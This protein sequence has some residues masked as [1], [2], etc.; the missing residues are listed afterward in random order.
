MAKEWGSVLYKI[1]PRGRLNAQN[2]TFCNFGH[3]PL[4]IKGL[5]MGFSFFQQDWT[6]NVSQYYVHFDL[7]GQLIYFNP[8][9]VYIFCH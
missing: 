2:V 5:N 7:R 4:S 8:V 3:L 1:Y 6:R 9:E